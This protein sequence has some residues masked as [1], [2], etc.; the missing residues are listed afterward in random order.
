LRKL[1]K[2]IE[3]R[4]FGS[5]VSVHWS[6]SSDDKELDVLC[7]HLG[8]HCRP[9]TIRMSESGVLPTNEINTH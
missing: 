6:I 5:V 2:D 8:P 4:V 1:G 3:N 9:A 7:A